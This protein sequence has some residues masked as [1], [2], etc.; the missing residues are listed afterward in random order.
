M[1]V[2]ILD[3][4]HHVDSMMIDIEGENFRVKNNDCQCSA[5]S[6]CLIDDKNLIEVELEETVN[7]LSQ[8]LNNTIPINHDCQCP[9]IGLLF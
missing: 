5:C 8:L 3:H 2:T 6:A 7:H 9:Q 1:F 4:H